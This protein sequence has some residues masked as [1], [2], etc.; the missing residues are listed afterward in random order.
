MPNNTP[1]PHS[2]PA[3]SGVSPQLAKKRLDSKRETAH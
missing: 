2:S 3:A 1:T